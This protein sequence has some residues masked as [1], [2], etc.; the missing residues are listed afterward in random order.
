MGAHVTGVCSTR[1]ME[2]VSS[3]GADEVLDY[4][5]ED[6]AQ[7]SVAYD[8]F[9]DTVARTSFRQVAHTLTERGRYLVTQFGLR[10]LLQM[11][12]TRI[13]GSKRVLGGASNFHWTAAM[14]EELANLVRTG[15]LKTVIDRRYSLDQVV[16]A[17][18]YVEQGHKRGNVVLI[19]R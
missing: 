13:V 5:R 9:F 8:V 7:H 6:F 3:L 14:L 11:A 19:L 17:H 2:L 16:L 18:R 10:E 12:L 4:T 15:A 1:N